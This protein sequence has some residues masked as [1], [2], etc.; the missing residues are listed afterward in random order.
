[1]S[2]DINVH[3][4]EIIE[5]DHFVEKVSIICRDVVKD[6]FTNLWYIIVPFLIVISGLVLYIFQTTNATIAQLG[7]NT[8]QLSETTLQLQTTVALFGKSLETMDERSR[9]NSD[10]VNELLKNMYE[11]K[12]NARVQ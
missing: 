3:I 11:G 12:N 9:Q 10:G 4:I 2:D 8:K 1:M 6:F 5:S 7:E